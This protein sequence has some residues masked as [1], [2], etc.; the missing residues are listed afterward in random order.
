MFVPPFVELTSSDAE[1]N[2]K[3]LREAGVRYPFGTSN[4]NLVYLKCIKQFFFQCA[5]ML[6][7]MDL[8]WLIRL[9]F[10][11]FYGQFRTVMKTSIG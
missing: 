2:I 5:N 6:L 9:V 11:I 3:K 4:F 7:L 1:E 10:F 8:K